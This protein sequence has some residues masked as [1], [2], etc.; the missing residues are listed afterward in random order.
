MA[1]VFFQFPTWTSGVRFDSSFLPKSHTTP[2]YILFILFSKDI[3]NLTTSWNSSRDDSGSGSGKCPLAKLLAGALVPWP[4]LLIL[5]FGSFYHLSQNHPT[6]LYLT[7]NK[8][9]LWCKRLYSCPVIC[10]SLVNL[11][12]TFLPMAHS[13]CMFESKL[14]TLSQSKYLSLHLQRT[15]SKNIA[16]LLSHLKTINLVLYNTHSLSEF[17]PLFISYSTFQG[18]DLLHS[19]FKTNIWSNVAHSTWFSCLFFWSR[20][21]PPRIFLSYYANS[22][23]QL[24]YRKKWYCE[25]LWNHGI[26]KLIPLNSK[27]PK[28][29]EFIWEF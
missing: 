1:P 9:F 25:F 3:Q 27:H 29:W 28:H 13:K 8:V 20:P 24:F 10:A 22:S 14:W 26:I 7:Q 12:S 23:K 2:K 21:E 16:M 15:S 17:H 6:C 19:I 4:S 5:E 11:F 18:H